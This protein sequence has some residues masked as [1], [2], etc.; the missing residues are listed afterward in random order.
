MLEGA[1]QT[2]HP[3]GR[4]GRGRSAPPGRPRARAGRPH[5]GRRD[6][7]PIGVTMDDGADRAVEGPPEG[8]DRFRTIYERAGVGIEQVAPDGRLIEVN[9]ALCRLL[10][11]T[12]EE[13]LR[14][15]YRDI[16]DP[17]DLPADAENMRR[18]FAG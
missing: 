11:Y 4:P 3:S 7:E 9:D 14:L 2:D 16:T 13:L 10:G 15:T 17:D 5:R 12:R 6:T 18:L 8:E 1:E